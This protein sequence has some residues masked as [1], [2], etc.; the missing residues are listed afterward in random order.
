[1]TVGRWRLWVA[2]RAA[3]ALGVLGAVGMLQTMLDVKC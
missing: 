1:M 3:R 2:N